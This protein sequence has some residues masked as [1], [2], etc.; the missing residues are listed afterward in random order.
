[1]MSTREKR[2][3]KKKKRKRWR[4]RLK[5]DFKQGKVVGKG[6]VIRMWRSMC[7]LQLQRE[8]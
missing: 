7:R 5:Q 4:S 6:N 2:K 8:A 3:G 1:M